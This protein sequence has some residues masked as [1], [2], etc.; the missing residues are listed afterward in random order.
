M[1]IASLRERVIKKKKLKKISFAVYT[2]LRPVKTKFFLFFPHMSQDGSKNLPNCWWQTKSFQSKWL[3][4][5]ENTSHLVL[6]QWFT[7]ETP[8]ARC[9]AYVSSSLWGKVLKKITF[10]LSSGQDTTPYGPK[11]LLWKILVYSKYVGEKK[12][13]K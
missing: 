13:K 8:L 3:H 6:I 12:E 1:V 2:Y 9:S 11:A 7:V 10:A 4:W 5:T